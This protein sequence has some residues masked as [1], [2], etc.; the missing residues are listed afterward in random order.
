MNEQATVLSSTVT[1]PRRI[2]HHPQSQGVAI[3]V[4][5]SVQEVLL[6]QQRNADLTYE[7]RAGQWNIITETREEHE[8]VRSTVWRAIVEEL[9][10]PRNNFSVMAGT[11][12]ETNER[13]RAQVG[14]QYTFR[15]IML[16]YTEDSFIDPNTLFHSHDG[17]LAQFAW[18]PY[19]RLDRYDIEFGARLVL[20]DYL[21]VIA[22]F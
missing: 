11:Y 20:N 3:I 21:P 17:E 1:H 7:R 2:K 15:C 22:G 16:S 12:R 18:V 6:A 19:D 13:Y 14:Y 4:V 8:L 10:Q 9:G 5:N